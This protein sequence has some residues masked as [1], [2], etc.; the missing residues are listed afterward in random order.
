VFEGEKTT[1]FWIGLIILTY[2]SLNLFQTLWYTF[3]FESFGLGV[4]NLVPTIVS[5]AVF[6]ILGL[7]MMKSGVKRKS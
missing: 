6:I 1:L 4:G 3:F 2:G 5:G 7:Y